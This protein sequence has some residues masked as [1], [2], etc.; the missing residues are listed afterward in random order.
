MADTLSSVTAFCQALLNDENAETWTST[1]LLPH[2]N[3]AYRG[4]QR[5]LA[6]NQ[7]KTLS[8][9]TTL[10]MPA[11]TG[12]V[13]SSASSPALPTDFLVPWRLREKATGS[14][15]KYADM[16]PEDLLPDVDQQS[17]N[18]YWEWR[19]GQIRLPG[20]TVATTIQLEYER[21]PPALA[22]PTDALLINNAVDSI[23]YAAAASAARSRGGVDLYKVFSEAAASTTDDLIRIN[24]STNQQLP[25]RRRGYGRLRVYH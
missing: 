14:S 11:L 6:M 1:I 13:I 20:A 4:L 23:A 10:A 25:R 9:V 5:K 19:A 2:I 15:D 17:L 7:I 12:T 18:V 8:D 3:S 21:I 16:Y 24:L 22:A